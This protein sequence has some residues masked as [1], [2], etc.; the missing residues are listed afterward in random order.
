MQ[1]KLQGPKAA[2]TLC[3]G[4]DSAE[5]TVRYLGWFG[6]SRILDSDFEPYGRRSC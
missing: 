4:T 1:R 2:E 6:L 3:E 5:H